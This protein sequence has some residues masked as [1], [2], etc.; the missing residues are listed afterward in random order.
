VLYQAKSE[1]N[2]RNLQF[3]P[4]FL[5]FAKAIARLCAG[6]WGRASELA[7]ARG[8]VRCMNSGTGRHSKASLHPELSICPVVHCIAQMQPS[9]NSL[10]ICALPVC[11]LDK[12]LL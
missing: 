10:G 12:P 3:S 6:V 4:S 7:K 2:Q 11:T 1:Q 9:G 8:R 5:Y